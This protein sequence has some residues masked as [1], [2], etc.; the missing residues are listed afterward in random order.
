VKTACSAALFQLRKG[1]VTSV[2][3]FLAQIHVDRVMQML[4]VDA[5]EPVGE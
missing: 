1:A 3:Q 2:R 4:K 5:S